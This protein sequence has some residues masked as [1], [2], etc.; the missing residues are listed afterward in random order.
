MKIAVSGKGGV[1]KTL[2]AGALAYSFA[3]KGFKTIAIDADPSPNLALT[4]GVPLE[5]AREIVPISENRPLIESKTGTEFSGVYRLSFA[6]DDVVRDFSVETPYGVNLVVM[7]TIKSMG[8]GC[9]CPANA[10]IRALL[11][12]LIVER[13]EAVV[14]DMEAGI[15]H[16]GRGTAR[17]VDTMLVVTDPTVKS[18]EIAKRIY[19]LAE[20]AGIKQIFLV[21]NKVANEVEGNS[22]RKFAE[23]N[24]MLMLSLIPFDG[25]VLRAETRGE[26]PLRNKQ[27]K[28]IRSIEELGKKLK[29]RK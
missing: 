16:L 25:Q 7:S 8:S 27:S 29:Q 11:R 12:Y 5:K 6:V 23:N 26:T 24:D 18:L 10:V 28:A 22:I 13:D 2:V 14:V 1:G 15:E 20:D 17:H 3:K 4:L 9:T 21:G 19:N